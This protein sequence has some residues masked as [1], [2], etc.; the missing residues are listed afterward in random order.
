VTR[1]PAN[2]ETHR[3]LHDLLRGVRIAP[4]PREHEAVE[5]RKV[6]AEKF[7]ER[8]LAAARDPA[9]ERLVLLQLGSVHVPAGPLPSPLDDI[10]P[11]ILRPGLLIIIVLPGFSPARRRAQQ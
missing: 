8:G 6:L 7:F 9:R 11:G 5:P 3:A 2:D 10:S 4:D 1:D